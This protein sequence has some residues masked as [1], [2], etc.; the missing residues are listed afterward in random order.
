M[1]YRTTSVPSGL[2]SFVASHNNLREIDINLFEGAEFIK[3]VDLSYNELTKLPSFP[4]ISLK[5]DDPIDTLDTPWEETTKLKIDF[6]HNS[7]KK[8]NVRNISYNDSSIN[9]SKIPISNF[10]LLF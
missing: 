4:K 2:D 9:L 6:T 7:I 8:I 1:L 10:A 3:H 5:D